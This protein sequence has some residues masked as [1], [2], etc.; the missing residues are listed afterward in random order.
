M[1]LPAE[2]FY[3]SRSRTTGE[4]TIFKTPATPVVTTADLAA[5]G[6]TLTGRRPCLI[7]FKGE[8][9][10]TGCISRPIYYPVRDPLW[11]PVGI[12]PPDQTVT[13]GV[14]GVGALR[15]AATCYITYQH[16]SGDVLLAESNPSNYVQLDVTGAA[17]R[18]WGNLTTATKEKRVTHVAGYVSLNGSNF[19]RAFVM[20]Y[21]AT[22]YSEGTPETS[23]TIEG[24]YKNYLPPMGAA[25][26]CVFANRVWYANTSEFPWRI[27]FS[28]AGE[29]QY[30]DL[31]SFRDTLDRDA[32]SGIAP[33]QG[34]LIVFTL[35]KAYAVRF[36]GTTFTIDR[37][38]SSFGCI[39]HFGAVE[40]HNKLW[41]PSQ[42]GIAIY[43]GGGFSFVMKDIRPYWQAD[44]LEHQQE[45]QNGFA[46]N[47][48]TA[49]NYMFIIPREKRD[50]FEDWEPG[51]VAYVGN[52][53][54]FEPSMGGTNEQPDWSID[55]A[56]RIQ[57]AAFYGLDNRLYFGGEDGAVRVEDDADGSDSGD[58][59][60]KPL[61]IDHGLLLF[62]EPGDD[63]EQGKKLEQLWAYCESETTDWTFAAMMGDEWSELQFEPDN[64]KNAAIFHRTASALTQVIPDPD[65]TGDMLARYIPETNHH[66][67]IEGV[68]GRGLTARVRAVAPVGLKYRGFGGL[69]APGAAQRKARSITTFSVAA[70]ATNNPPIDDVA[71]VGSTPE[72]PITGILGG[73]E[74]TFRTTLSNDDLV[75][76]LPVS[77]TYDFTGANTI[78][79]VAD[80]IVT[81]LASPGYVNPG[82][83]SGDTTLTVTVVLGAETLVKTYYL[84]LT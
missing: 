25:F 14:S 42:D 3:L 70:L 23:L 2:F 18:V 49:K 73:E 32:I 52:Y 10:L 44:Y 4:I 66:L 51:H 45:F 37:I 24:P 34:V 6:I 69:W 41:F 47:N 75:P 76:G 38:D 36:N 9:I 58:T 11:V 13:V 5:Q 64:V 21:G 40:I 17:N 62:Q 31:A 22:T 50:A 72:S 55:L 60:Q 16:R 39:S 43:A 74:Y 80:D 48:K 8:M 83:N 81:G 56:N 19:R 78:P 30:V 77:V 71:L 28:E 7:R 68:A 63:V 12:R 59:L 79:G 65:G 29:G 57:Y 20:P 61:R 27:W 84:R 1:A 53:L 26:S 54:N 82:L 33:C 67:G 46:V 15:G 35:E